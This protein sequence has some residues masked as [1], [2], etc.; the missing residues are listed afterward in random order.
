[1]GQKSSA[2]AVFFVENFDWLEMREVSLVSPGVNSPAG[3]LFVYGGL[4]KLSGL[5]LQNYIIV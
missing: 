3:R 2:G 4:E 5:M 1:V